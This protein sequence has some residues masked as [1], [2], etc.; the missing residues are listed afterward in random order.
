MNRIK[1]IKRA[2]MQSPPEARAT[3]AEKVNPAVIKRQ[4][5]EVIGNWIDEWRE[6]KPK[7]ARRAFADLFGASPSAIG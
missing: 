7:D 3:E 2:D 6:R 1:I 5:V 4:A